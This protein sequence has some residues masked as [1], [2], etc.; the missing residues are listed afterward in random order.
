M[1]TNREAVAAS[2][3][4]HAGLLHALDSVRANG[5][6]SSIRLFSRGFTMPAQL[7]YTAWE[8]AEQTGVLNHMPMAEVLRFSRVYAEQR[9]Y[10]DA[11]RLAGSVIYSELYHTGAPEMGRRGHQLASLISSQM[12]RE[13][14]LLAAYEGILSPDGTRTPTVP[15]AV[16]IVPASHRR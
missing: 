9:R 7:S 12:Y 16:P 5:G 3:V 10:D 2:A 8:V 14:A 1:A 4:Y 15:G 13:R 11:V 6:Q